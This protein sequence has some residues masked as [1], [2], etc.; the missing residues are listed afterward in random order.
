M[1]EDDTISIALGTI[2]GL[3]AFGVLCLLIVLGVTLFIRYNLK[4]FK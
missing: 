4:Y 1:S 3:F 2:A